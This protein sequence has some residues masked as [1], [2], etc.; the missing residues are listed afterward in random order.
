MND[1]NHELD[2][3]FADWID[4]RLSEEDRTALEAELAADRDLREAAEAYRA[5]VELVRSNRAVD[6]VPP[7]HM[8]GNVM[9]ALRTDVIPP[10]AP[11][12]LWRWTVGG[13]LAAAAGITAVLWAGGFLTS[14]RPEEDRTALQP[15]PAPTGAARTRDQLKVER[16]EDRIDSGLRV[17]EKGGSVNEVHKYLE[18]LRRDRAGAVS[19][20]PEAKNPNDH[21]DPRRG[22][23]GSEDP[24]NSDKAAGGGKTVHQLPER[25]KLAP[26]PSVTPA[27]PAKAAPTPRVPPVEKPGTTPKPPAASHDASEPRGP[28]TGS[29]EAA[30]N[31]R[32]SLGDSA[33]NRVGAPSSEGAAESKRGAE[34]GGI[35]KEDRTGTG[36]GAGFRGGRRR[37]PVYDLPTDGGSLE[38]LV[39]RELGSMHMPPAVKLRKSLPRP[40]TDKDTTTEEEAVQPDKGA[41]PGGTQRNT[42]V[43]GPTGP[44]TPGQGSRGATGAG[45]TDKK[46][47]AF[48]PPS[49]G[50]PRRSAAPSA[51]PTTAV[52]LVELDPPAAD[53]SQRAAGKDQQGGDDFFLTPPSMDRDGFLYSRGRF[54]ADVV[55]RIQASELSAVE[56]T[57][58]IPPAG[59]PHPRRD[60]ASTRYAWQK[61]DIT[62]LVTGTT[63]EVRTVLR[64][65][66][67]QLDRR[68]ARTRSANT[69]RAVTRLYRVDGREPATE[70]RDERRPPASKKVEKGL[71]RVPDAQTW[72]AP[73]VHRFYLV[74]RHR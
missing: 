47:H 16:Q 49:A 42:P 22:T 24:A 17:G 69:R 6:A 34:R 48:V 41:A 60:G 71:Q 65:L 7:R 73:E 39:Q 13:G 62:Y 45:P 43:P 55:R 29:R 38:Q 51:V 70:L 46:A 8:V 40:A 27:T 61:G 3:R 30:K 74:L 44:S 26:Q 32:G 35:N 25:A 52:L 10:A 36:D 31:G 72:R 9:E 53:R 14:D 67:R 56:P 12:S 11:R 58:R 33:G 66:R 21:A 2:E 18:K 59:A 5:T 4:Q 19:P 1:P 28:V 50:A 23:F 68:A 54:R 63:E 37:A 64:Q 57:R 15:E 20:P